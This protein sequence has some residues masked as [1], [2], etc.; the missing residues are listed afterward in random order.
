MECEG[1]IQEGKKDY[2]KKHWQAEYPVVEEKGG[3]VLEECHCRWHLSIW[4]SLSVNDRFS[5]VVSLW[6]YLTSRHLVHRVLYICSVQVESEQCD[7]DEESGISAPVQE[8]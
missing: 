4:L 2:G 1:R 6:V 5:K 8:V 3:N 7:K